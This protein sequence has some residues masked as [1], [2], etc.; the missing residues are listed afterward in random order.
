MLANIEQLGQHAIGLEVP[1]DKVTGGDRVDHLALQS[2]LVN[3]FAHL[4]Q[5][6]DKLGKSADKKFTVFRVAKEQL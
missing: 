6:L 5:C 3:F 1:F 2:A 4:Q